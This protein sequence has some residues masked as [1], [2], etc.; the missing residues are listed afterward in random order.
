MLLRA[1]E[2]EWPRDF[3]VKNRFYMEADD[4]VGEP[5]SGS[6]RKLKSRKIPKKR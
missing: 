4:D 5:S 3:H 1:L 6:K 2:G